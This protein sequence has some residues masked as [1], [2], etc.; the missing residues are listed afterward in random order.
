MGIYVQSGRPAAGGRPYERGMGFTPTAA[1][2]VAPATGPAAPFVIA[3][4]AA[5]T[6]FLALRRMFGPNPLNV[7]ATQ[8]VD[9]YEPVFREN[10]AAFQQGQITRRQGLENFDTLWASML[11]DLS[12]IPDRNVVRRSIGDRDR[13][14]QFDWLRLYR[15]P[16]ESGG[17]TVEMQL[18]PA[19]GG[20]TFRQPAS[21]GAPS[22]L[23][24]LLPVALALVVSS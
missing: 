22:L 9:A 11:Q 20:Q 5:L 15:D 3:G 24:L 6:A 23:P 2:A 16:I 13:G 12:Q 1:F 17:E 19:P 18:D 10:L 14:G 21:G 8:I 4:V 7:P